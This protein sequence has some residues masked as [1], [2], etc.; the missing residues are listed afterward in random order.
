MHFLSKWWYLT[1]KTDKV[2][3]NFIHFY[4]RLLYSAT[5]EIE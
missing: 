3:E 1:T 2:D 4:Y 5:A